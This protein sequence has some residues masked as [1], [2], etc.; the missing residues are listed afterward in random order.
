VQLVIVRHTQPERGLSGDSAADPHLSERGREQAARTAT[1]LALERFT[2]L[3]CSPMRRALETA[4]AISSATG[5]PVV[6]D[7]D[8][9]EFDRGAEYVHFEDVGGGAGSPYESYMRDDLSPWGTDAATFRGRVTAAFDRIIAAHPG[10]S[11]VVVVHGGVIN[12]YAGSLIGVPHIHFHEPEY[13]AITRVQASRSGVR[14]LVS[15]NEASHLRTPPCPDPAAH[16]PAFADSTG[17]EGRP[18]SV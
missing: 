6:V 1:A 10:Q 14:S 12:A 4:D 9:A 8:L 15:L 13:G 3:Y 17:A 11:V 5:L 16:A 18:G 2:A 7:E